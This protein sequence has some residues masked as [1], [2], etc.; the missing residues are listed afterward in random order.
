MNKFYRTAFWSFLLLGAS[1]L[2]AQFKDLPENHWSYPFVT[3]LVVGGGI[4]GYDTDEDG[5][6]DEFRPG[7][8][9]TRAEFLAV[10]VRSVRLPK[11]EKVSQ[12]PYPD[13]PQAHWAAPFAAVSKGIGLI[14]PRMVT[15][16]KFQPNKPITRAEMAAVLANFLPQG[17][18]TGQAK[19]KDVK[20][21]FWAADGILRVAQA[22]VVTGYE[23]GT[24]KPAKDVTRAEAS[25]MLVRLTSEQDVARMKEVFAKAVEAAQNAS[26][27]GITGRYTGLILVCK[28]KGLARSRAP[29]VYAED[30]TVVYGEMKEWRE[31]LH[32]EK[33]LVGYFAT[34]EEATKRAGAGPLIVECSSVRRRPGVESGD[35]DLPVV[36]LSDK[37]KILQ[38]NK[39]DRFLERLDVAIVH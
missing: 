26:A 28:G 20:N 29:Q 22:G 30:G 23:D 21:D 38:A 5:I 13:L 35:T 17:A 37:E 7:G 11:P 24:F 34:E 19:F 15:A 32:G 25:T 16:G 6:G 31:D 14:P 27:G 1:A 39:T 18:L 12:A 4:T 8:K 3:R 10:L 9:I 2:H 36:S 33:G